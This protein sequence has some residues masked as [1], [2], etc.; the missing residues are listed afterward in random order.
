MAT[1]A[2]RTVTNGTGPSPGPAESARRQGV[3]PAIWLAG[4]PEDLKI[5]MDRGAAG[6]IT[7]TIVLNQMVQKYGQV[8]EVV[9]RYLDITDKPVIVEIDG[10]T[11]EE[12]V[13]VGEVFTRMS[14][15]VILKIPCT[16]H[17][18]GAFRALKAQ[19]VETYCTTVFSLSQA[20]AVAQAGV[21]HILPFL[22]PV[23][24][25]GGD[26]TRL[27]R[28]CVQMFS[29]WEH[30]PYITAALVRSVDT[31]YAAL[32]DGADSIIVFWPIFEEMMR[33]PL[34]DHWNQTFLDEWV[35]MRD[36]GL[37]EGV[38]ISLEH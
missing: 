24:D 22:V 17:A 13:A 25:L 26:P 4:D 32:K 14:D 5:W 18:L 7:N 27:V 35:A 21:T 29:G 9:Q 16:P 38:P 10:H 30:R 37:T 1:T 2:R 3:G 19:G 33:H 8:I 23:K 36:A 31:A 12:L 6:I 11:T 15:Q 20:A 28:D 34:T